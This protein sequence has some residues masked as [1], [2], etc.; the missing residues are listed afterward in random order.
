[1][2]FRFD[3]YNYIVRLEKGEPLVASL[4]SLIKSNDIPSCWISGIGGAQ[5]AEI[6]FYDLDDQKYIWRSVNE[7]L[8][9]VS[10]Q[11]NITWTETGPSLHMHGVFS[12]RDGST[13]GGHVKEAVVSGT[14]ELFLHQWYGPKLTRTIDPNI[15]LKL[16]DI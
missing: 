12:K 11:G 14:C 1:M 9:I 8:E 3:G 15:G 10:L 7:A 6:G 5:Q 4:M 13:V 16:L 2:K